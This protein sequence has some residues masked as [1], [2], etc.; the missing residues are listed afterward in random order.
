MNGTFTPSQAII[1]DYSAQLKLAMVSSSYYPINKQS[2][3]ALPL[4]Q[5]HTESLITHE[6]DTRF[7]IQG[8]RISLARKDH[9]AGRATGNGL[10]PPE[11]VFLKVQQ[12][13]TPVCIHG[14]PDFHG[15]VHL[16]P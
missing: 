11:Q 3:P 9:E 1:D 16:S 10:H 8:S 4:L 2:G 14:D 15:P 13:V 6:T 12:P 7:T 5:R